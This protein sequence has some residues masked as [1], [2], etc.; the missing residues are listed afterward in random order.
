MMAGEEQAAAVLAPVAPGDRRTGDGAVPG[1]PPAAAEPPAARG[2]TE[3]VAELEALRPAGGGKPARAIVEARALDLI[4]ECAGMR[5]EELLRVE[6]TLHSLGQAKEDLRQWQAAVREA[7]KIAA[8]APGAGAALPDG[9]PASWP[10]A[11]EDNRLWLLNEIRLSDGSTRIQRTPIA[12]FS[13]QIV[14]TASGEDGSQYWTLAGKTPDGL[15]FH[16]EMAAIDFADERQLRA[17]LTQAAG[18]HAPVRARMG[19]HLPA[20]IQL[21]SR[22]APR[23]LR[24]FERTGWDDA[25]HFLLPGREPAGARIVLNQ[26]LPY[27][28]TAEADLAQGLAALTD[29]IVALHPERTMVML[30]ALVVGP[31]AKLAGGKTSAARSLPPAGPAP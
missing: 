30:S 23:R 5:R 13:A 12:D 19:V 10:Y 18:P 22:T 7:A 11:A 27:Q 28:V 17:Q 31:M 16:L 8:F 6:A 26:A 14:E 2:V 3:I 4:K 24:R 9:R 20:A 21:C 25:G 15:P 29:L 1:S